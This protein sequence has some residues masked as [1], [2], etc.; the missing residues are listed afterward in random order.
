MSPATFDAERFFDAE[1]RLRDAVAEPF[2][3]DAVRFAFLAGE[4]DLETLQSNPAHGPAVRGVR[5]ALEARGAAAAA[6]AVIGVFGVLSYTVS[7]QASEFGI[8]MALGATADRVLRL[9]PEGSLRGILELPARYS[10][11]IAFAPDGRAATTATFNNLDRPFPGE[12][13]FHDAEALTQTRQ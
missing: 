10:T 8:R 13:R 2:Q 6:L 12:V 1:P 5:G 4:L 7:Q 9:T 3:H 11:N